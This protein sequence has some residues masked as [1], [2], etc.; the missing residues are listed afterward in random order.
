MS[1]PTTTRI[2]RKRANEDV[3]KSN[4]GIGENLLGVDGRAASAAAD[5]LSGENS[6]V[7]IRAKL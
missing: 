6:R 2:E 1:I 5:V 3:F 7:R 4:L